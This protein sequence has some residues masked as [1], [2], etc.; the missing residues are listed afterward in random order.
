MGQPVA[1]GTGYL[2]NG[3]SEGDR[4]NLVCRF[5]RTVILNEVK[6]LKS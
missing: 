6:N 3:V 4:L 2:K 1:Q 5:H